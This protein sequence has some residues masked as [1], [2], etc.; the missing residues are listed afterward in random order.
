MTADQTLGCVNKEDVL[1][2]CCSSR[3]IVGLKHSHVPVVRGNTLQVLISERSI[4]S[5]VHSC[6]YIAHFLFFSF[7]IVL[8]HDRVS[9]VISF[10]PLIPE[11]GDKGEQSF[12][13][14][15]RG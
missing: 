6:V 1:F 4:L 5:R 8:L 2:S 3:A 13:L 7:F 10:D 14:F 15:R 12:F 11:D 9:P